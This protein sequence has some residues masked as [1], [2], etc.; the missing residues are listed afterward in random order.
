V[1][2]SIMF[3]QHKPL[4]CVIDGLEA[5]KYHAGPGIS[6]SGLGNLARS[7]A[8]Y[9]ALHL[10][11]GRPPPRERAGQLEGTLAHCALLEPG[12]FDKRYVVG[13]AGVRRGTKA[14]DAFE[15]DI[16]PGVTVIKPEQRAVAMAQAASIRAIP[17]VAELLSRGWPEQSAYW[18]DEATGKLCRCRPDWTY[19]VDDD[20]VI[21]LDIKTYSDA[22]PQEFARQVARKRY[23]VQ[24]AFYSHGYAQASGKAVIGFVFVAVETEYPFAACACTLDDDGREKG[25]AEFCRL[26]DLYARCLDSSTWPGYS[27]GVNLVTVPAWAA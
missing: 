15:A 23:H 9:Y 2:D 26:L 18:R 16:A 12:E 21:L 24:D 14:W 6:N 20:R 3:S 17:D 27:A 22:S 1:T 19:P 11:P 25:R 10:D 5:D 8:H 7:P 4:P 13:P